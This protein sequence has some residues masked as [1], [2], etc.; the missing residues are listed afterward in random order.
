MYVCALSELEAS[1][2]WSDSGTNSPI[3]L[4]SD[5]ILIAVSAGATNIYLNDKLSTQLPG[6]PLGWLANDNVLQNVT[7]NDMVYYAAT[8]V[9]VGGPSPPAVTGVA[10]VLGDQ[11]V[12]EPY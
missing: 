2:L 10:Y 8:G 7:G 1:E 9:P 4:S 12:T 3:Y 11:L 5:D 6:T